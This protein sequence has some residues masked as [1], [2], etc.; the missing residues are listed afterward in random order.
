MITYSG[1]TLKTTFPLTANGTSSNEYTIST[2]DYICG[3]EIDPNKY[4]I[5]TAGYICD[6]QVGKW[7]GDKYKNLQKE[8][9]KTEPQKFYLINKV[10]CLYPNKVYRFTFYN[11]EVIKTV[12]DDEDIF[13]FEFAFY[14]A[15][16]KFKYKHK[17]TLEGLLH[18]AKELS[19]EIYYVKEVEHA[20]KQYY[21]E[22]KE[23]REKEKEEA[24]R[25]ER[26]RKR[27]EKRRLKNLKK[28]EKANENLINVIKEAIN[29]TR[30]D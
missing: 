24:L 1:E 2:A 25:K 3:G 17:Y 14:L 11:G 6:D 19:Y 16:A 10:E 13:N 27:N 26:N 18:K 9:K 4:T 8:S 21:K 29:N 23:K 20:K 30:E 5:S 15:I 22:Q 7:L 28:Q 12:C